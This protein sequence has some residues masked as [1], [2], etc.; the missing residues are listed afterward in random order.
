MSTNPYAS[1][2]ADSN[3]PPTPGPGQYPP[4]LREDLK[5]VATYQRYVLWCLLFQIIIYFAGGYA[6]QSGLIPFLI[7]QILLGMIGLAGVVSAI[8]LGIRVYGV[9][10]GILFGLFVFF[11]CLGLVIL[12]LMNQ[13]ATSYLQQHGIE[14][15]FMGADPDAI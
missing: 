3:P 6:M 4:G 12:L 9:V 11:P 13:R 14:V 2:T 15:G 10:L 7:F 8:L 5:A 1:P